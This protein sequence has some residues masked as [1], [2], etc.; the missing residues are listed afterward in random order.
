MFFMV[1]RSCFFRQF[2]IPNREAV[3]T[4]GLKIFLQR[5]GLGRRT[6]C[7]EARTPAS[8][9]QVEAHLGEAQVTDGHCSNAGSCW[10]ILAFQPEVE[11]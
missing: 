5:C 8:H 9:Q 11:R 4:G 10:F 7:S 2:L 1:F 6:S 3:F